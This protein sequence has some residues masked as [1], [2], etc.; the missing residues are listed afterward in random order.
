MNNAKKRITSDDEKTRKRYEKVWNKYIKKKDK[1]YV[2]MGIG[3]IKT[4][5]YNLTSYD[6]I[7]HDIVC[8]KAVA[9]FIKNQAGL[10]ISIDG[11]SKKDK[12]EASFYHE[13]EN[14]CSIKLKNNNTENVKCLIYEE[15]L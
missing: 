6:E 4:T 7:L 12:N 5:E 8:T 1:T 13:T 2:S 11:V 15:E 3:D 14:D 9:I 10:Y